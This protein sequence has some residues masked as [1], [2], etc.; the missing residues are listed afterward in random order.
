MALKVSVQA[1][2]QQALSDLSKLKRAL[3]EVGQAGK[4]LEKIT[5]GDDKLGG[6]ADQFDRVRDNFYSMKKDSEMRRVMSMAS[7]HGY[8]SNDPLSYV[9]K[10]SGFYA[11]QAKGEQLQSRFAVNLSNGMGAGD[12]IGGGNMAAAQA[13]QAQQPAGGGSLIG[14]AGRY[15]WNTGLNAISMGLGMAGLGSVAGG[16]YTAFRE[17]TSLNTS[18]ETIQ[19]HLTSGQGFDELQAGIRDLAKTLQLTSSEAGKLSEEF[20]HAS[21]S[22]RMAFD[23]AGGAGQFGRGL[24]IDPTVSAGLFGKAA[25]LGVGQDKASQRDFAA[26]L[27]NTIGSSHMFARSEQVMEDLVGHIGDIANREGRTASSGEMSKFA[28]L[29]SSLYQVDALRGGGAQNI[30]AGLSGLG[31]GG[32][33]TKDMFAWSAFGKAAKYDYITMESFKDASPFATIQDI[34]GEGSDTTTKLDLAWS[35]AKRQSAWLPGGNAKSRQAYMLK[36]MTGMKMPLSEAAAS[37]LDR[38]YTEEGGFGQFKGWLGGQNIDIN[39]L[40]PEGLGNL[41]KLYGASKHGSMGTQAFTDMA[42]EYAGDTKTSQADRDKLNKLLQGDPA[43]LVKALP[44]IVA[45]TGAS[46]N[47][48]EAAR[49]ATTN[50]ANTLEQQIGPPIRDLVTWLSGTGATVIGKVGDGLEKLPNMLEGLTTALDTRIPPLVNWLEK[51]GGLLGLSD[52]KPTKEELTPFLDPIRKAIDEK[53]P[54]ARQKKDEMLSGWWDKIR[55]SRLWDHMRR[56]ASGDPEYQPWDNLR[57]IKAP[58]YDEILKDFTSPIGGTNEELWK[59]I[60]D[61]FGGI[62]DSVIPGAHASMNAGDYPGEGLMMPRP[63]RLSVSNSGSVKTSGKSVAANRDALLGDPQFMSALTQFSSDRGIDPNNVLA[64]MKFESAGYRTNIVNSYGYKGLFQA[65]KQLWRGDLGRKLKSAGF[66]YES[67]Q[68]ESAARQ[69][70]AYQIYYDHWQG[71]TKNNKIDTLGDLAA[72]QLAPGTLSR[73]SGEMY[74]RGTKAYSANAP[75]DINKDGIINREEYGYLMKQRY[76]DDS[77]HVNR[78]M[79]SLARPASDVLAGS[80]IPKI[81]PI[82]SAFPITSD[83]ANAP[84]TPA[85]QDKVVRELTTPNQANARVDGH[86]TLD[87]VMRNAEGKPFY[88]RRG[89]ALSEPQVFGSPGERKSWNDTATMPAS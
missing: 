7:R 56:A 59:G 53:F 29:L 39:K 50:L 41:A 16:L 87:I 55:G 9:N 37:S 52:E 45:R 48:A 2:V 11:N 34:T 75:L 8:Q 54:G 32:D 35:E 44:E 51:I 17:N 25:L 89:L 31:G 13:A 58:N 62:V 69:M 23:L 47:E 83:L 86:H 78:A 14:R 84:K 61:A 81:D 65:G 73:P 49:I 63:A 21:G 26:L 22:T 82:A 68:N 60:K 30:M 18:T 46:G 5:A 24:G 64:M 3:H 71:I 20:A 66:S 40:N 57:S 74:R 67:F 72:L 33:L 88:Q 1:N 36:L 10:I 6:V 85:D 28:G 76:G 42:R 77:R 27:A 15:A 38:M 43:E 70:Q 79:A 12:V 80:A 19:R 4:T